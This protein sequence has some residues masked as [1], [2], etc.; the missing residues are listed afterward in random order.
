MPAVLLPDHLRMS[1]TNTTKATIALDA[2]GG[3]LGPVVATP[4]ALEVLATELQRL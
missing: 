3:N 4:A 2:H 1:N